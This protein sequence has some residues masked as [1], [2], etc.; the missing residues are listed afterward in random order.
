MGWFVGMLLLPLMYKHVEF[1]SEHNWVPYAV[2]L[3]FAIAGG[4]LIIC[5]QKVFLQ[6]YQ[7]SN[8]GVN[9]ALSTARTGLI[10]PHGFFYNWQFALLYL[11]R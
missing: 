11:Q 2:L 1:L 5:I 7:F 6:I 4:I 3:A 8:A 9:A 10:T